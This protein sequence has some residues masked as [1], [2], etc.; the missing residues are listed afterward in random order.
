MVAGLIETEEHLQRLLAKIRRACS[1]CGSSVM[2]EEF[3]IIRRLPGNRPPYV[4]FIHGV[5]PVGYN[6]FT[7]GGKRSATSRKASKGR[8]RCKR[9]KGAKA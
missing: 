4:Q 1:K 2:L 5:M 8:H 7:D 3:T 9:K 6:P